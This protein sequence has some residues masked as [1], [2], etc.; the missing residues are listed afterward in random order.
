MTLQSAIE[1]AVEA[2]LQEF[3]AT[4]GEPYVFALISDEGLINV[5]PAA[6]TAAR[7]RASNVGRWNRDAWI[8]HSPGAEF[9]GISQSLK[10]DAW[11]PDFTRFRERVYTS[12][13]LA[14]TSCAKR[15]VFGRRGRGGMTLLVSVDGLAE[16]RT[17]ERRSAKLLNKKGEANSFL[18]DLA[19]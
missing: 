1:H 7:I 8:V 12:M 3:R 6:N 10:I 5:R 18:A 14:I 11:N 15:G 16:A 9:A 2:W 4:H 19:G 13:L 17:L